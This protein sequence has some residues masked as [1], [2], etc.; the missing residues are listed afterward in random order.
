MKPMIE[1]LAVVIRAD[2]ETVW[3]AFKRLEDWPQW[4]TY[5]KEVTPVAGGW[6]FHAH[7]DPLVDQVWV[8]RCTK[9]DRPYWL[10][11][12]CVKEAEHNLSIE[13]SMQLRPVSDGTEV[14]VHCEIQPDFPS[15]VVDFLADFW[16]FA[17]AEPAKFVGQTLEDFKAYVEKKV[18]EGAT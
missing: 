7:G 15:R 17:F 8:V 5:I 13:G 11:W 14:S 4:S 6:R 18:G 1:D 9:E 16:A 2:P 3:Q 12:A 10:E